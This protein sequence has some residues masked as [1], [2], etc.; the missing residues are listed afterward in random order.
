MVFITATQ[1]TVGVKLT[2][3][4]V[5]HTSS[6]GEGTGRRFNN[7]PVRIVKIISGRPYP[8]LLGDDYS[9]QLGWVSSDELI[10]RVTAV[11][12]SVSIRY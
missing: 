12:S 3:S 8:I 5:L 4:G 1:I 6:Y 7:Y 11:I 10:G 9:N 2:L